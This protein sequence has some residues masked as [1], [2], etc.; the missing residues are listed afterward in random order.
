MYLWIGLGI[1][2]AASGRIREYCRAA[3]AYGVSEVAFSL[4]QHISLKTSFQTDRYTEII[5]Y[6]KKKYGNM[7]R[8]C[9]EREGIERISGII[10]LKIKEN[11][12]LRGMHDGL[13]RELAD[14]FGIGMSGY[15]GEGFTFHSTLFFAPD[16]LYGIDAL[17]E[18]IKNDIFC[19]ENIFIDKI[20]F[21]I[22]ESGRA[23][24]YRVTDI[25]ELND[26]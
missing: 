20:Y 26:A 24:D 12:V 2:D 23:G 4:P 3:N 15:D 8:F 1:E 18:R 16:D 21:G 6:L 14:N 13:N 22:S 10:W 17:F 5:E 9:V 11:A 7:R 25:I 19:D